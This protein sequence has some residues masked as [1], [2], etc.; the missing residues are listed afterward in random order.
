MPK[1]LGMLLDDVFGKKKPKQIEQAVERLTPHPDRFKID[2][3]LPDD[4]YSNPIYDS[5]YENQEPIVS[6][7]SVDSEG[8]RMAAG[9]ES[10]SS[11]D[12]ITA[13][14]LAID[15]DKIANSSE[16][17]RFIYYIFS[18]KTHRGSIEKLNKDINK[19]QN[20][21]RKSMDFKKVVEDIKKGV[22][23]APMGSYKYE[24]YEGEK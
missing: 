19:M 12:M 9:F 1:D 11:D 20:D 21:V 24:P 13:S 16:F 10:R 3:K 7:T 17:K 18:G 5:D 8:S 15:F 4:Y 22:I 14:K 2:A 23:L 6:E